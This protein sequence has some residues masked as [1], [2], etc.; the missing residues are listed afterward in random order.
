MSVFVVAHIDVHDA[1]EYQRYLDGFAPILLDHGGEMLAVDPAFEQIEGE[2]DYPR[3]V[4]MR[5]ESAQAA[6][7][8]H[9]S[10]AFRKLAEHRWR[11]ARSRLALVRGVDEPGMTWPA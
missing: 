11:A 8:W 6:K 4:I 5:F 7:R 1:E 2:W 3:L 10:P 9:G